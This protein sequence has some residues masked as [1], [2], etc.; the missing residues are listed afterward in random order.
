MLWCF[1]SGIGVWDNG[2]VE[3]FAELVVGAIV[4]MDKEEGES[5]VHM[6]SKEVFPPYRAPD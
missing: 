1:V 6:C 2:F 3:H 5:I 4:P